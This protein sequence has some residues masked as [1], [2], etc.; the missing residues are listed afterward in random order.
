MPFLVQVTFDLNAATKSDY[1]RV[2]AALESLGMS[3]SYD[4]NGEK[5]LLPANTF[6]GTRNTV[7]A[8]DAI[9][10]VRSELKLLSMFDGVHGKLLV[11]AAK[12]ESVVIDAYEF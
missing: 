1:N 8:Q 12:V 2:E 7:S 10:G 4:R 9:D 11:T 5:L 6:I 3:R